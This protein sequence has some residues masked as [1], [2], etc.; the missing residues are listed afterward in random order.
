MG[1]RTAIQFVDGK[2]RSVWLY[3]HYHADFSAV[4]E[5]IAYV[6]GRPKPEPYDGRGYAPDHVVVDFI[7]KCPPERI[8]DSTTDYG[9]GSGMD[10]GA[11][12]VDVRTGIATALG[13]GSHGVKRMDKPWMWDADEGCIKQ[14][15]T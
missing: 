10:W 13:E 6:Q 8:F 2:E 14:G 4:S 11:W 5:A 12:Q 7:A 1:E 3:F 9:D 15:G